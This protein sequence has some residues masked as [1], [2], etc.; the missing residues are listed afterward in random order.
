MMAYH[1]KLADIVNRDGRFAYEAYE[2]VYQA[3]DHT[4]KMLGRQGN[5]ADAE[6]ETAANAADSEPGPVETSGHVSGREI[7]DG[8]RALALQEFGLMARTV[9]RQ[10]G[11]RSSADFGTI[12]FKLIDANLMR[13][14][15]EDSIEDFKGGFDFDAA[16]L[17][18]YD[19][20]LDEAR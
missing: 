15:E 5:D 10:W 8:I 18:G 4:L 7:L 11:L 17:E 6:P 20:P 13:K 14:T 1:A 19:I 2:F 16:L 9:F 3:L 12:I